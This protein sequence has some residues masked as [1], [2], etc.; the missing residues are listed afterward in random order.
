[1]PGHVKLLVGIGLL[2]SSV[3]SQT[4]LT[5]TTELS[6]VEIHRGGVGAP[7]T[8]PTEGSYVT[9]FSPWGTV[10]RDYRTT[11][12]TCVGS[13][14]NTSCTTT[15]TNSSVTSEEPVFNMCSDCGTDVGYQLKIFS[16]Q[17]P[18]VERFDKPIVIVPGFDPDYG[19]SDPSNTFENFAG[20]M[21]KVYDEKL[22]GNVLIPGKN[23][24]QELYDAGYDIVFIKFYNP[25]ID[26]N[27]NAIMLKNAML[28][29]NSK[30]STLNGDEPAILGAS[31][32]GL[33]ARRMLQN[34]G[35]AQ[36]PNGG[37]IK[38]GLFISFDAPNRGAEI[39]MS[40]QALVRYIQSK[41]G[42][43]AIM[44]ANIG[45]VA[46][47]QMLLAQRQNSITSY[48]SHTITDYEASGTV[49]GDFMLD[50]N[51]STNLAAIKNIK[52]GGNFRPIRTVAISNGS[53]KGSDAMRGLP[54][55][56][57]FM[58]RDTDYWDHFYYRLG[59][60]NSNT[61]TTVFTGNAVTYAQWKYSLREPVFAENLPGGN[62]NSY[63]QVYEVLAEADYGANYW[64]GEYKG[65]CFIPTASALGLTGININT[66]S[67]WLASSGTSMFDE[68][69]APELNQDH[70]AITMQNKAWITDAL[71]LYGPRSNRV[72]NTVLVPLQLQ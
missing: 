4:V 22:P 12:Q 34:A 58:Y 16:S 5:G 17:D 26:I 9:W 38:A 30:S 20:M 15:S 59:F 47:G 44:N 43:A 32:G 64:T 46:A 63:K 50:I 36:G 33:I 53:K 6:R 19:G 24:L 29:L 7:A 10:K 13:G 71:R 66:P 11:T 56:E 60:S 28:W 61:M 31:M 3:W 48:A 67:G 14:R 23:F 35:K 21:S 1:M 2:T 65:H 39:P 68:I 37:P 57:N 72:V 49:H 27:N 40:V 25:N 8:G 41:D 69:R 62:R 45:S 54:A 51:S 70:V 42:N 52:A 18:R 55:S